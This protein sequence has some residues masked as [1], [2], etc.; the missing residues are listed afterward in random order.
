M[1]GRAR[2]SAPLGRAGAYLIVQ[3]HLAPV[4]REFGFHHQ[5]PKLNLRGAAEPYQATTPASQ[6]ITSVR[7]TR[8]V[9]TVRVTTNPGNH[10]S[11]IALAGQ[12]PNPHPEVSD[13]RTTVRAFLAPNGR[14]IRVRFRA[15][16]SVSDARSGYTIEVR[17]HPANQGFLVETYGHNVRAGELVHTTVPLYNGRHGIYLIVV[18]YRSVAPHPGPMG[19]LAYPGHLVGR[20]RVT[21]P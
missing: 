11:C 9:C 10:G 17:P 15:R 4:I 1:D 16:Q 14:G 3:R 13:V 8:G 21:V 7:Y 5:D 6:V 2:T 12:T 18:R 19:S 20:Q